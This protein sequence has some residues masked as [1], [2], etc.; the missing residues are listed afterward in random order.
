[1]V[2]THVKELI[3]QNA[4]KLQLHWPN[5]PMGIYSAGLRQRDTMLPIIFGGAAS[6]VS[7]VASF[8]H[9]D[10]VLID[11]CHLLSPKANTT[12]QIIIDQLMEINPKLR[13]IGLSATPYRMGQGMITDEGLFTHIACDMTGIEAFNWFIREGHLAP[14][15]PVKTVTERQSDLSLLGA[16]GDY[17]SAV[18]EADAA[19]KDVTYKALVELC[20]HG[21]NRR[22]WLIFASTVEDSEYIA[23]TLQSF[24]IAAAAVHSKMGTKERDN[25]IAAFKSGKLRCL[26]NMGILTT[27]FDYPALD[28]IGMLRRTLS[29]G[30]WVQML[31]RGTRPSP[32][33]GKEDCLVL[34]FAGNTRRLGPIND[35]CIPRKKGKGGGDAPVRICPQCSSYNH[36]AAR[37]CTFCGEE[38]TFMVHI[39]PKASTEELIRSDVPVVEMLDVS[40]VHYFLHEK[41]GSPP[42]IRVDYYCSG[43]MQK[44][45]EFVQFE[46]SHQLSKKKARDWWRQR[47]IGDY[48]PE[49]TAEALSRVTELRVPNRI[50]VWVNKQHPEIMGHEY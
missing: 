6:V 2:L 24:G 12:Y 31:G 18:L 28:L 8:G 29:T 46:H 49:T 45:T 30:L 43:G 48:V 35:P 7:K 34:D 23:E 15:R 11:E 33:T 19:Q 10:L 13:V 17:S 16:N 42:Q 3:E 37:F 47:Y 40:Q 32:E 25:R 38:F 26:V 39:V 27:G 1:M 9:R 36:A 4:E 14:L 21:A 22:A 41:V 5:A 44:F 20:E 50:K